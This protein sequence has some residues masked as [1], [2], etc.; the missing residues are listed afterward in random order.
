[1]KNFTFSMRLLLVAATEAE[2]APT[3]AALRGRAESVE[4]IFSIGVC[5]TGVGMLA[6]AHELTKSLASRNWDYVLGVGIAGAFSQTLQLGECV[7]VE[8]EQI[9]DFGA[10]DG[11]D[12]L[13][14][15][16]MGLVKANRTPFTHGLIVNHLQEPPFPIEHLPHVAGL[17]VTIVSGHEPTIA[18]RIARHSA[19]VET[20]EGAALHYVCV[21]EKIPFLQVRAISNYV[22]RRDRDAWRIADA[23]ASLNAQLEA[24]LFPTV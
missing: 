3:L 12:F 24:W 1:M 19:A 18:K 10:E 9:A 23:I 2:I 14:V 8:S 16:S 17:T 20:M 15:F 11:E 4:G 5:I 6:A 7:V 21:K 22:T 13:D